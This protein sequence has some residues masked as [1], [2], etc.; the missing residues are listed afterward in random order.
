[1]KPSL[2]KLISLCA[3]GLLVSLPAEAQVT[4]EPQAWRVGPIING[5]RMPAQANPWVF[6]PDGTVTQLV[7]W[8]GL[9]GTYRKGAADGQPWMFQDNLIL[10]VTLPPGVVF[11]G[12]IREPDGTDVRLVFPAVNGSFETFTAVLNQQT[13]VMWGEQI[14]GFGPGFYPP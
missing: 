6:Y 8:S 14:H 10:R 9:K 1:M 4:T 13:E 7:A 12:G 3:Y 2:A 5:Q 11:S